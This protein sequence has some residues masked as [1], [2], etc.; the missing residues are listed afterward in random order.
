MYFPYL[1]GKQFELIAL[2]ELVG[3]PLN[4]EKIIPIIEPVKKNTSSLR[5]ALKALS[6]ANIRVQLVVN[7]EHG[8]LKGDS[9][10]IFNLIEEL[11]DLGVTSIIPTYLIKTD[12]DSFFAQES[13]RQRGF[14]DSGYALVHLNKTNDIQSLSDFTKD[15]A[16]LYNTIHINNLFGLKR[17]YDNR[18]LLS[19]NF[20]KLTK[21][22]DY[23]GI[24]EEVFSTDYLYYPDEG[25]IA[26]ADYQS[27]GS[28]YSEGGGPAYAVAIHLTFKL[29]GDEDIRIA[30]FVSKSN[31]DASDPAR[32]Y[33]EALEDLIQFV[34]EKRIPETIAIREFRRHYRQ[35]SFSGLG[36]VKKLSIMHH[37]EL[38]QGLI[39]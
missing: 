10:S 27:I 31:D 2:R 20:N 21:N 14:S 4:P 17:K 3:L 38:I 1:R 6:G 24:R 26:F 8:E 16:C 25:C 19:D 5:T 37:I 18:A 22:T 35:Q 36:V 28:A 39:S 23:I 30:H 13:I 7:T 11:K 32:K 33:F 12:R 9:E 34:D 15:T 29:D